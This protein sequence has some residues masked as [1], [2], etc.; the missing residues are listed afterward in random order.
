L[1]NRRITVS[2]PK[3]YE[4]AWQHVQELKGSQNISLYIC[5]LINKDLRPEDGKNKHQE[6]M[7]DYTDISN[8]RDIENMIER[9]IDKKIKRI[10]TQKN[11]VRSD[12]V[13]DDDLRKAADAFE[14]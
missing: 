8:A 7:N 1:S 14:L 5:E 9:I 6:Y 3:S 12:K 2:F 13:P 10:Y 4:E 11:T